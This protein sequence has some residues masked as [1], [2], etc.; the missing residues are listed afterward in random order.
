MVRLSMALATRN[1]KRGA[2][3]VARCL[4]PLVYHVRHAP[5]NASAA[6]GSN[7][8]PRFTLVRHGSGAVRL[9]NLA[10]PPIP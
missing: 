8:L 6:G 4:E 1:D 5:A 7:E 10:F 9:T 3:M 2:E